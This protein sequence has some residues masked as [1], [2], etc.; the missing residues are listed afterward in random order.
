MSMKVF[1]T[2]IVSM[3]TAQALAKVNCKP[4]KEEAKVKQQ[5][6]ADF[7]Y[8]LEKIEKKVLRLESKI[9]DK[10]SSMDSVQSQINQATSALAQIQN[11]QME[12]VDMISIVEADIQIQQTKA[13]RLMQKIEQTQYQIENL[14]SGSHARRQALRENNR[15]KKI[16]QKVDE[17]IERLVQ[18]I[19]PQQ[20]RISQLEQEKQQQLSM[21]MAFE[22][23]KNQIANQ[24]PTLNS[25]TNKKEKAE[26]ELIN[27]D[28]IQQENMSLLNEAQE[29]VL[30]CKTYNVKY[31][32]ALDVAK[33][34]YAVGCDSYKL[35][36]MQ[37]KHKKDAEQ[38]VLSAVCN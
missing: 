13:N 37:G 35:R 21:V 32:I 27:Q 2:V 1:S 10:L 19:E 30:M 5:I 9:S 3:I 36:N 4:F 14:P 23:E 22:A 8:T 7:S 28:M 15:S 34:V 29:K 6:V 20:R 12:L 24:K 18:S 38:E 11:E 31:P 33:E 17:K 16:L 25:L 26:S